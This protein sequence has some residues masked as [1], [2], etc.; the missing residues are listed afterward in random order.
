MPFAK[1]APGRARREE[2]VGSA[3]ER[4]GVPGAVAGDETTAVVERRRRRCKSADSSKTRRGAAGRTSVASS[5]GHGTQAQNL[6]GRW[7]AAHA[8]G[9]A[10]GAGGGEA[11]SASGGG[12]RWRGP[13][14]WIGKPAM[15]ARQGG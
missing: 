1:H 7:R 13:A 5:S 10:S 15:R 2:A 6:G 3:R 12:R 11:A 14:K 4:G 9:E 8:T